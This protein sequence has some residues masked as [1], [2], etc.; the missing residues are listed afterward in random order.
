MDDVDDPSELEVTPSPEIQIFIN[1][2]VYV[3]SQV[4][5]SGHELRHLAHPPLPTDVDLFVV[6]DHGAD[7]LVLNDEVVQLRTGMRLF[8]T[9]RSILAG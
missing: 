9:P 8:T 6:G 1:R 7:R 3:V 2:A 5:M 4:S